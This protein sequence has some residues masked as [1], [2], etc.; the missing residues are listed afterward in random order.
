VSTPVVALLVVGSIA[1]VLAVGLLLGRMVTPR[2]DLAAPDKPH[3]PATPWPQ[4]SLQRIQ[5]ETVRR[6]PGSGPD[7]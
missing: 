1:V 6:P 4:P 2:R 3:D 5:E 7:V